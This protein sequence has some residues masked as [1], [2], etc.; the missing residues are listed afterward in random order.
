MA[1]APG[2]YD[3]TVQRRADHSIRLEFKDSSNAAINLTGS[4][5][6]SQIWDTAR[7]NKHADFSVVYTDRAA[8]IIDL[9]LTDVQTAAFPLS[10]LRYDVMITD[11]DGLKDYYL[12]GTVYV[13]EGYSA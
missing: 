9:K 13:D 7:A 1:I 4:T 8:G 11:S 12:E 5:V 3:F 6:V 2:T 10:D